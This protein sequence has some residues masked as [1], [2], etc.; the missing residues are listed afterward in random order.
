MQ[1]GRS[2]APKQKFI[3]FKPE[4]NVIEWTANSKGRL[5]GFTSFF[6]SSG[7]G[8][9]AVKEATSSISLD[10]IL[11]V[12]RGI[13]TDVLKK[14]GLVDPFCCF[15]IVTKD[16]TL[17]IT[18]TSALARD[19]AIRGLQMLLEYDSKVRFL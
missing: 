12:R 15:S 13:Q 19:M 4:D 18:M 5:G 2:G 16:R 3:V 10:S 9:A 14:A 8:A 1:H 7:G 6:S 17:D 11:E